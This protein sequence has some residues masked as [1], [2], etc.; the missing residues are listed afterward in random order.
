[1]S[2]FRQIHSALHRVFHEEDQRIVFW[3]DPE[4]EFLDALPT[5][6]IDGVSSVRLDQVGALEVKIRVEREEP[7]PP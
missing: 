6:V 7:S 2:D 4:R 5:V 1:V 3:N